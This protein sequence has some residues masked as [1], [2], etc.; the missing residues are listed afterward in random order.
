MREIGTQSVCVA[1]WRGVLGILFPPRCSL[2]GEALAPSRRILLCDRCWESLPAI[3]QPYCPRCGKWIAGNAPVPCD[4]PCGDC[5]LRE[6]PFGICRSAG[7][8]EGPLKECVHRFKFGG[9]RELGAALGAFMAEFLRRE[10]PG[11][12]YDG[13]VP[14]P[15]SRRGLRERGFDQ[16]LDLAR[17]LGKR[18]GI[19]VERGM[20][21]RTGA[22]PSQT[23]L[24]RAERILNARGAFAA[25]SG[26]PAAGRRLLLID[27]V[28][29][30]GATADACVRAL[31]GAGA[32]RVD[33]LT[34]ARG[35]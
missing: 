13:C 7:R 21:A 26:G 22:R 9:A 33:V 6:P 14:V 5:R 27:D 29:T 4:T 18:A 11:E 30:T 1:L 12:S 32:A 16:A 28:Y 17:E 10:L 2:C 3:R 19:P 35:A 31:L 15:A 24:S 23:A 20:L 8:Y 34:L 25:R